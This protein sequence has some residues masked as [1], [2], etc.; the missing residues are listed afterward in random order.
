M[1][2]RQTTTTG[3]YILAQDNSA[4][5]PCHAG[6]GAFV[7]PFLDAVRFENLRPGVLLGVGRFWPDL[8]DP[9][10]FAVNGIDHPETMSKA[11][12]KRQAEFLAGRMMVQIAQ[13]HLD[14]LTAQIRIGGRRGPVWPPGL[15]GSITHSSAKIACIVG[16]DPDA[17]VGLDL[18]HV[19]DDNAVRAIEKVALSGPE[20]ALLRA[21]RCLDYA[22]ATTA[23][24]SA[25]ETL[26]KAINGRVGRHFG[27]DA[28]V[29]AAPPTP[30]AVV[31]GLAADLGPL[32]PA[33]RKFRID[34]RRRSSYLLTWYYCAGNNDNPTAQGSGSVG[35][36]CHSINV[37][38]DPNTAVS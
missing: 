30:S 10:L 16:T 17:L 8:F 2:T 25:K 21:Q 33:G 22:T 19:A 5:A 7:K 14:V 20:V 6:T 24:F 12:A 31:L 15:C 13:R 26:F 4:V 9:A 37:A 11:I 34:L 32:F 38:T 27:F 29:L 3:W 28:A 23:I 18:E 1:S 35:R 36:T